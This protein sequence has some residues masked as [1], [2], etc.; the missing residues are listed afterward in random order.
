MSSVDRTRRCLE[1]IERLDETV[2][3]F[4]TVMSEQALADAAAIDA[5]VAR[6]E[7][8]G[9]LAGMPVSIKDCI[10]VAGVPCTNGSLFYRDYVPNEDAP[11][12]HRLRQGGAVV[13]GKTN[14]HEFGYGATTQN[15]H[16]GPTRNPWDT[17]RIPSGSSGGAAAAVAADMC[18][19]AVG[20]DT[21]GSVRVPAAVNG[22]SGLRPTLGAIP[23][24]GSKTKLSPAIDTV[25]PMARSV[26]D[27][28]HMF[29]VMAFYDDEDPTSVPHQWDDFL[30]RLDHGIEGL[31]IGLPSTYFFEDLAPDVGEAVKGA[32]DELASMGALLTELRLE[33]AEEAHARVMPMVW[34]DLYE[35]HRQRVE[36][37]PGMFGQ[38]V[39]DRILL[40]RSVSGADYAAALRWREH[41]N[42]VVERALRDLDAILTPTSPVP[43]PLIS[44]STDMLATTHQLTRF[45]FP[46]SWVG[47]PG[48]SIPCGFTAEGLPIGMQLH[49]RRWTEGLLLRMGVAYQRRTDWHLR[50]PPLIGG[51]AA[52]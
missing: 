31:R 34:A 6:G 36:Q 52:C 38:D 33:G 7:W 32:A 24:S 49:G 35:F 13:V 25:G 8:P 2:N 11:I 22:V 28:T 17:D 5:A 30:A 41:W 16:F 47:V 43:A 19:A 1:N 20:S 45:T 27:L 4:I 15:P 39:L 10:D 3:A 48:L 37:H 12:V 29:A 42:R 14:L 51:D 46:F 23:M 21:G 18:V 9:L 44:E 50:R 40:G 26:V